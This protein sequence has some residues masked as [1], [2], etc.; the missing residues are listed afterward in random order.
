MHKCKRNENKQTHIKEYLEPPTEHAGIILEALWVAAPPACFGQSVL[1]HT[2]HIL[3]KY[4]TI[5]PQSEQVLV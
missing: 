1:A 3:M 2:A 4:I 5:V